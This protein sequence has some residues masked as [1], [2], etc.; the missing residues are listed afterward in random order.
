MLQCLQE[1]K[2]N[3][4]NKLLTLIHFHDIPGFSLGLEGSFHPSTP[5]LQANAGVMLELV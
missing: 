1:T 3:M 2:Q 4:V 5:Q